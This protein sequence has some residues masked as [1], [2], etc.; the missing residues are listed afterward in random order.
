MN[1]SFIISVSE[2]AFRLI[3]VFIKNKKI[4]DESYKELFIIHLNLYVQ[5]SN[6]IND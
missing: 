2:I 4:C 6:H 1:F 5:L 3:I